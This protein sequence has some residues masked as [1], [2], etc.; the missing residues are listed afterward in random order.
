MSWGLRIALFFGG[1]FVANA[2]LH[3]GAAARGKPFPTP[4]AKPPFRGPSPPAVNLAYGLFNAA[5][6]YLLLLLVGDFRI[7]DRRHLVLAGAGF[8]WMTLV[9]ARS[10]RKLRKQG[11]LS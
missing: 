1:A 6:A 8:A 11:K 10:L 9:I 5:V 2:L 3:L 7:H 4:F